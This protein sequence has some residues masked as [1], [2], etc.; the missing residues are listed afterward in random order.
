[1]MGYGPI[2]FQYC[3]DPMKEL[4]QCT[5]AIIRQEIEMFEV[6]SGCETQNRYQVFIQSPMGIK[7]AFQCNER[8]GCCS[9]YCCSNDRRSLNIEIRHMT[10]GCEFD[11][12]LAKIYSRAEKPCAMGCCCF[13]WPYIDV[14][15]EK[16]QKYIG[17]VR[18][19]FTCCDRDA[20]LY[21]ELGE[22]KYRIVGNCCQMGFC[23]GSSAEKIL[24]LNLKLFKI[25]KL[26][27]WWK[28]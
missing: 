11:S 23:C 6:Y 9:R 1:M 19:P 15:L 7:Y 28:K 2:N 25:K 4:N 22:L 16:E 8:S 17:K 12:D 18:E 14:R 26:L 10:T 27:E 5:G 24:K 20:E 3:E 13:C 21:N